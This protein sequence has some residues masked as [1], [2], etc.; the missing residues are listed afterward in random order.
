MKS[1]RGKIINHNISYDG[2]ISFD[3]KILNV[4]KLDVSHDN[5]IIP[6]FVD[7]H[8][9]GGNSFDVM[10]GWES[11]KKMSE[12]HLSHGTTSIAPTTWTESLINT[13]QALQGYYSEINNY[14][15]II[16][17]HLEGPFI[18]PSKLGAQPAKTRHPD[19][20]FI[21]DLIN[22]AN[23]KIVT[24]A[25]ELENI[26]FLID[27]LDANGIKIQI[28]HSLASYSQCVSLMKKYNIGFTHLYNAMSG[29]DHREPGVATAALNHAQFAEIIFDR[30]HVSPASFLLA[31]KSIPQLYTI[32]DAIGVSGLS[33]GS[34]QFADVEVEKKNGKVCQKNSNIL[35]G[36]II[37]MHQTFLNILELGCS[38]EETVKLTSYNAA[39]Y[40]N[41]DLVGEIS[42]NKFANFLILNKNFEIQSVFLQGKEI[43]K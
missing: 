34:Y 12:F 35:A 6:G 5:Y 23:I 21:K 19:L 4:T 30:H 33:D 26:R 15:N 1:I 2:E 32:T 22:I 7:L 36:S 29:N 38:L 27:F 8:C 43:V 9:H 28:G 18:N 24:L 16:G 42:I 13:K 10:Q 37:T 17:I 39:K 20:D 41:L 31:K 11:I 14:P 3:D 25:P 40:L